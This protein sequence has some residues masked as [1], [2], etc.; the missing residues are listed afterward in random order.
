MVRYTNIYTI[1]VIQAKHVVI[2]HFKEIIPQPQRKSVL[3]KTTFRMQ[4]YIS[5]NLAIICITTYGTIPYDD[6]FSNYL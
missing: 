2:L 5:S 1:Q 4:Y 3:F 6:I